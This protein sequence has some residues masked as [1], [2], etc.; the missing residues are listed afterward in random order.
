MKGSKAEI[1]L[2]FEDQFT[3]RGLTAFDS[4]SGTCRISQRASE[5]AFA[6]GHILCPA[7]GVVVKRD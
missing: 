4:L 7:R 1:L 5:R 6:A 2:S 3:A